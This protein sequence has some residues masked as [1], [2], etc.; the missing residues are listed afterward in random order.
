MKTHLTNVLLSNAEAERAQ[1]VLQLAMC[2]TT[3]GSDFEPQY[4]LE[5]SILHPVQMGCV[6]H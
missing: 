4:G 2:W 1:S 5:L 6:A 3:K